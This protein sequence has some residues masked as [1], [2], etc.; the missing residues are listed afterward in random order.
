MPGQKLVEAN[1]IASDINSVLDKVAELEHG[2]GTII[3]QQNSVLNEL[4]E[5]LQQLFDGFSQI[6]K[7]QQFLVDLIAVCMEN[8]LKDAPAETKEKIK[9]SRNGV[10]KPK[11]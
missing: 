7:S 10:Y 5:N 4:R 2:L 6:Y 3:N 8:S 9:A 11:G 1:E